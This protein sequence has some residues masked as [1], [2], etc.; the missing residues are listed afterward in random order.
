MLIFACALSVVE[1][2][3]DNDI[4]ANLNE[5]VFLF[6]GNGPA[7]PVRHGVLDRPDPH[8]IEDRARLMAQIE[9]ESQVMILKS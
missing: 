8:A 6:S 3:Y 7:V 2:T 5:G 9:L 1:P 4:Q